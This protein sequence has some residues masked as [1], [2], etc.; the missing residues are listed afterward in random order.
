MA[1]NNIVITI[2]EKEKENAK[3]LTQSFAR[4]DIKSR[5]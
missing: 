2:D 3:A 4:A 1:D 5:A